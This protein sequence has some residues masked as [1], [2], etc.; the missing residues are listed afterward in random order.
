MLLLALLTVCWSSLYARAQ[1]TPDHGR[2]RAAA[3]SDLPAESSGAA[4]AD[5]VRARAI[6][7]RGV[8]LANHHDYV[9]AA[10]R[11]REAL[12]LHRAPAI[13]Y[14][15]A[16][17]LS[18]T[19]AHAEAYDLT[20]S[21]LRDASTPEPL[22]L[23][24]SRL[25]EALQRSVAR[26]TVIVSSEQANVSIQ[27]DG[28]PLAPELVGVTRAVPPGDHVVLAERAGVRISERSVRIA[29]GT[30]A[31]VDVSLVMTPR[32]AAEAASL[33]SQ[34]ASPAPVLT[35]PSDERDAERDEHAKRRRRLWILGG[36]SAAAVAVGV[37]LALLLA[38]PAKHTESP[39]AG[40]AM[41][42]VLVWK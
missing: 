23:R 10:R 2:A 8:E 14:N 42:G 9:G 18:E 37:A 39:V 5:L 12:A 15:L 38:K 21:V 30:A 17:A 11:F 41:P 35:P 1:G 6:F 24:A 34:T 4:S 29:A 31:L 19:S 40:D 36:A 22:R 27:V 20:Q 32:E 3:T 13:A 16:S 25:E 28:Q 7:Q 26:L 33:T